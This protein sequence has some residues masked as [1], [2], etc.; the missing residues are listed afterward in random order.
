MQSL[1]R[2][3]NEITVQFPDNAKDGCFSIYAFIEKVEKC[4]QI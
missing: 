4:D 2:T 3:E 1:E